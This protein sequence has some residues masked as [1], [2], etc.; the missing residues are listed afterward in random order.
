MKK[1]K[2]IGFLLL[3]FTVVTIVGMFLDDDFYWQIY[4]YLTIIFSVCSGVVLIKE[5]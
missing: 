5:K 3:I 1:S 2:L 4:N